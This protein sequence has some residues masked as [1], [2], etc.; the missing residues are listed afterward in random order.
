MRLLTHA[1][2]CAR[3]CRQKFRLVETNLFEYVQQYLLDQ[4]DIELVSAEPAFLQGGKAEVRPAEGCL[5]YNKELDLDPAQRLFVV[6]HELGHLELHERLKRSCAELDPINS[7]I[8]SMT[9]TAAI[10]RYNR[11]SQEEAQA[12]AF[13]TE[14]LCPSDKVFNRWQASTTYDSAKLAK[15]FGVPVHVVH[16]QLAEALQR[17]IYGEAN[18]QPKV[19]RRD[20]ERD[21][22]QLEAATFTGKPALINAGPGTGK[23]ATLIRRIEHL[24]Q[25]LN[26]KP[27]SLL[28]L[29]FSNEAA[30]EV[31]E[32]I[33][34]K[35]GEGVAA[36]I[37][38]STFHGFGV[39]LLWQHGQFVDVDAN[40]YILDE[41]AQQELVTGILGQVECGK[42]LNIKRPAETVREL[43]RHI[44][45]VKN[46]HLLT[47]DALDTIIADWLP[48]ENEQAKAQAIREF[49]ALL[50]AY[51]EEKS[52]RKRLDFADLIALPIQ[53]LKDEEAV[54]LALRQRYQWIMV[55]EY[56]D[57]SRSVA[58]L[59][60]LLCGEENPPWVV[61]DK[62]QSI[63]RFLGAAPENLDEFENDF[64]GAERFEL[65]INRRSCPE[66]VRAANQLAA[67]METPNTGL[68]ETDSRWLAATTN[69]TALT[70][71]PVAVA[72]AD[73]DRAEYE[74]IAQQIKNW[75]AED[76]PAREIVV[77]A[78]RNIDVRKI[79]LALGQADV[80]A[81]TSGLVTAEGAAGDLANIATYADRPATAIPRLAYTLGRG[82]Y[83]KEV[84]SSVVIRA[85]ETLSADSEL[86][87]DGYGEGQDLAGEIAR[88]DQALRDYGGDA[89]TK[90]CV[91]LFDASDYL[92]R[93]L[94]LTDEVE[95]SLLL[96]EIIATLSRAASWRMLNP[97]QQ[98]H[99]ARRA[100]AEFF[101]STLSSTAT[102][103]MSAR[104]KGDA[105]R[106]MTCHAA[107][108]LEFPCVIVAGQTLS[109]AKPGFQWLPASLQPP[110]DD[111][112][113]QSDSLFF[114]GVTRAQRALLVSYAKSA[115]GTARARS[116]RVTPLLTDWHQAQQ[117]QITQVN[118]P[119]MPTEREAIRF[120]KV[121]GGRA[122]KALPARALDKEECAIRTYM[123]DFLNLRYPIHQPPLYPAFIQLVRQTLEKLIRLAHETGEAV[124]IGEAKRMFLEQWDSLRSDDHPHQPIYRRLGLSYVERFATVYVPLQQ[125]AEFFDLEVNLQAGAL[126]L[127]LD[128]IAHY[129]AI[130]D[131]IVAISFRP[132]SFADVVKDG[133]L[134]WGKLKEAHRVSFV[135]LRE[136]AP[137]LKAYVYSGEDGDLYPFVWPQQQRFFDGQRKNNLDK[138]E[139]LAQPVFHE[140]V[141]DWKCDN[142]CEH[143]L[144]CPHWLDAL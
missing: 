82:R 42:L 95:R 7:A 43:V 47:P 120:G 101:R 50:R 124:N 119:L 131:S 56:Q 69:P 14:F 116:R 32:R 91:L 5:Y 126:R 65:N 111:S 24:L 45:H 140:E 79:V 117:D 54:Q 81:V 78:R 129:R 142:F 1:R 57:V 55:D 4:H 93:I 64:P 9:E 107:K 37:T 115:S 136:R 132:D 16:S 112:V 68:L 48:T 103:L 123:S 36:N 60:R 127:R 52:K 29:T 109:N 39:S 20:F 130:D 84:I 75:L 102:T 137:Q 67:L 133:A 110:A 46:Y 128:L 80:K 105:V 62:R 86:M 138:L 104:L 31:S 113:R 97:K 59:L 99:A 125:A 74:G 76:I 44:N 83:S 49:P 25:E 139:L 71:A 53:I 23:T 12:N 41:A 90:M 13:A 27:E 33:A 121:W 122:R 3:A 21:D 28:V 8:Y 70:N 58:T 73:S 11:R 18:E 2:E 94:T 100:F 22:S 88:A 85:L 143:R 19:I 26:A 92:R 35:F 63:F 51:E 87:T 17:L 15:E 66:V 141:D 61:G 40:A 10:A 72:I 106:V 114:F 38:V 98:P 118:F 34:A 6:L 30:D 96:E 135:L 108:G 144:T 134:Q 89:F 77:L